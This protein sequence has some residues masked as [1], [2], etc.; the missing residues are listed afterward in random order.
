[1]RYESFSDAGIDIPSGRT[2]GNIKVVCP[3]CKA[4]GKRHTKDKC[5]SVNIADGVWNCHKCGWTGSI[6]KRNSDVEFVKTQKTYE[7]PKRMGNPDLSENARKWFNEVRGIPD[8]VLEKY[9]ITEGNAFM[10]P[11][12]QVVINGELVDNPSTAWCFRN[13]VQFNYFLGDELVNVKYRTGDKCFGQTK[14]GMRIPYNINSIRKE[15]VVKCIICEGEIDA[16]SFITV[17]Y[18]N[19]TCGVI[20]VPNGANNNLDYFDDFMDDFDRLE[21]IYIASDT[22]EKGVMLREELIRRFG[23]ER[24]RIVTY[25]DGFKDA[26][27]LLVAKGAEGLVT[28]INAAPEMRNDDVELVEDSSDKLD[29]LFKYGFQRGK[30][31]GIPAVDELVSFETQ[32]LCIITGNFGSGKTE[33]ET[34]ICVRLNLLYGWKTAFFSPESMPFHYHMGNLISRVTGQPFSSNHI[35]AQDYAEAKRYISD[36]YYWINPKEGSSIENIVKAAEYCVRRK[37]IKV[38]VVDPFNQIETSS[39]DAIAEANHILNTLIN[40]SRSYD[41]LVILMAHPHKMP[42]DEEGHRMA[43]DLH[44]ISGTGD[45]ANKADFGIVIHRNEQRK[46]VEFSVK[47]VKFSHLG[48]IGDCDL[49]FNIANKR[50]SDSDYPDFRNWLH[51]DI[52]GEVVTETPPPEPEPQPE[53][54]QALP[55]QPV[56]MYDLPEYDFIDPLNDDVPFD[57][58]SLQDTPF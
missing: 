23:K 38:L 18:D 41:V 10:P 16:L 24:C 14:N 55:Q 58:P 43:P 9:R 2:S 31:I 49:F 30:T 56:D 19:E 52:I 3:N 37:G 28:A 51:E 39:N 12:K 11:P 40:F 5:L 46:C 17:G 42:K 13:T 8:D 48:R 44:D 29:I 27:E 1:M 34:E 6:K 54:A 45:F 32:R 25:G 53:P 4:I 20:S 21:T 50:Y 26:N 15:G 47:K 22:D 57:D 33:F 36:N 7:K 35:S